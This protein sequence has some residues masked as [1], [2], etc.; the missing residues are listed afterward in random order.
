M[1]IFELIEMSKD[2]YTVWY[3]NRLYVYNSF[4]FEWMG[5]TLL[6]SISPRRHV[7]FAKI[8]SMKPE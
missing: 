3:L 7:F 6:S 1:D 2:D 4:F 8:V 5:L